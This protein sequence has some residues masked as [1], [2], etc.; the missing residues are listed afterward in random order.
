MRKVPVAIAGFAAIAVGLSSPTIALAD[1]K[2][3]DQFIIDLHSLPE[4]NDTNSRS[5]TSLYTLE[6]ESGSGGE[7][8]Q[9]ISNESGLAGLVVEQFVPTTNEDSDDYLLQGDVDLEVTEER[10]EPVE[11]FGGSTILDDSPD[12]WESSFTLGTTSTTASFLWEKALGEF[13]L[14]TDSGIQLSSENQQVVL[15][16]L[17]AGS[18]YSVTI[19]GNTTND[20]GETVATD[21]LVNFSTLSDSKLDRLAVEENSVITPL[22][23]QEYSTQLTYRT[24]IPEAHAPGALCNLPAPSVWSFDGDNRGWSIPDPGEPFNAPSYRTIMFVASNWVNPIGQRLYKFKDVGE[25]ISRKDGVIQDTQYA[26][27]DNM[28]FEDAGEGSGYTQVRLNHAA[29]NPFC[30]IANTSY[31]GSI[32]YNTMVRLYQSGTVEVDGYRRPAPNH[33]IYAGLD[34]APVGNVVTKEFYILYRGENESFFCLIDLFC[35]N[36]LIH[37]SVSN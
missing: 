37:Q 14:T 21:R 33:E 29:A 26:S 30:T 34:K 27:M 9:L 19:S 35:E 6:E 5:S 12:A 4:T 22:V 16:G 15:E 3:S 2:N 17:K 36:Q 13:S 25:S 11:E 31:A 20:A 7:R 32:Q 28:L 8:F 10:P 24:F 23:H 18:E 1:Q